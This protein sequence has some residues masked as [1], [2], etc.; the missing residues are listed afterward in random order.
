MTPKLARKVLMGQMENWS[1]AGYCAGW[2]TGLEYDLWGIVTAGGG[3]YG[4]AELDADDA[5]GLKEIA[6]EAGGWWIWDDQC[7]RFG[8]NRFVPMAEWQQMHEKRKS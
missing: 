5:A 8:D 7:G 4:F 6:D 2:M 3:I 1:E